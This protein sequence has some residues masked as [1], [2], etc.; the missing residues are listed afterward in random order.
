MSVQSHHKEQFESSTDAELKN[1]V[2]SFGP[3]RPEG[4]YCLMLLQQRH[5]DRSERHLRILTKPHWVV[6]L[7]L[8]FT[9]LCFIA[10]SIAAWPVVKGWL[11]R[12]P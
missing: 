10:S 2:K 1:I 6:T 4:A 7:T 11:L 12:A 9:A 5:L 3:D 8:I